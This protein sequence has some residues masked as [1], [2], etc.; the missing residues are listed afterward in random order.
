MKAAQ[1]S[2]ILHL[3]KSVMPKIFAVSECAVD[4]DALKEEVLILHIG[5]AGCA[6]FGP[7]ASYDL[8]VR[9]SCQPVLWA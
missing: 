6:S 7:C 4:S 2:K 8:Y 9:G 5:L 3:G 1:Y